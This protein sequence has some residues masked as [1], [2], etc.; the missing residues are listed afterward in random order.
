MLQNLIIMIIYGA[1][2]CSF[3]TFSQAAQAIVCPQMCQYL[4]VWVAI[5]CA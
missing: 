4:P 5:C 2:F 3:H 1:F